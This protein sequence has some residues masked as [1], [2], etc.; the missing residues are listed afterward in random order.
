MSY[1]RNQ[2]KSKINKITPKRPIFACLWFWL[3]ILVIVVAL[4]LTY[5]LLFFPGLQVRDIVISGNEKVKT[6]DLQKLISENVNTGL[7]NFLTIKVFSRSIFLLNIAKLDKEILEEF[8]IIE[9]ISIDKK[10][11]QAV[12]FIVT[13]RKPVG[14]YCANS[15]SCYLIDENG[16]I[17]EKLDSAPSDFAIVR[18]I[19]KGGDIFVGETVVQKNILDIISSINKILNDKL[20][21]NIKEAL[22]TSPIRLN[23]R[24]SEG[25]KVYFDLAPNSDQSAQ[26]AKLNLLLGG[27]ISPDVRKTLKYIDLRPKDRAIICDNKTC[28]E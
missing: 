11:P 13:E 9:K 26:V 19:F 20:K 3:L 6:E 23:I 16:V 25:W 22:V 2:V 17:F 1:R 18:Q 12:T 15:E 7:I 10:W 27:E 21:I 28:A 4:T 8:P 24:T 5:F 14:V